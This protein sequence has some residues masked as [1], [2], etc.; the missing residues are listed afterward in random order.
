MDLGVGL[1]FI[2]FMF[3][4]SLIFIIYY[5]IRATGWAHA[6]SCKIYKVVYFTH[7]K[8][9]KTHISGCKIMHKYTSVTIIMHIFTVTVTRA[10]NILIF[11]SSVESMRE[12]S[13]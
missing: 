11:F 1:L 3:V 13:S 10:F 7:F 6:K 4:F 9:K 8:Q 5:I 12:R 2:Y